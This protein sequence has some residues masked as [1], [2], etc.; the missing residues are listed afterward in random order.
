MARK[1]ITFDEPL[2]SN[3]S[4]SFVERDSRMITSEKMYAKD[5]KN[6]MIVGVAMSGELVKVLEAGVS[7]N[8]MTKIRTKSDNREGYV[9]SKSLL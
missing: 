2:L 3:N 5:D 4:K 8:Q 6:S 1:K 7:P 9:N